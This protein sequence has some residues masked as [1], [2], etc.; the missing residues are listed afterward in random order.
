MSQYSYV[1]I[2]KTISPYTT[3]YQG[4]SERL[5]AFK[6]VLV[7]TLK[8]FELQYSFLDQLNRVSCIDIIVIIIYVKELGHLLTRYSLTYPEV[9]S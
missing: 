3:L 5:T 9:F 4:D 6:S 1:K 7:V 8:F 2:N